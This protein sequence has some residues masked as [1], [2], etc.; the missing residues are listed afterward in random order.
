MPGATLRLLLLAALAVCSMQAS[1]AFILQQY[2]LADNL[3][4]CAR[5]R[6]V[7]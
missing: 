6:P 2:Y 7:G 1:A 4:D 5:S 3:Q